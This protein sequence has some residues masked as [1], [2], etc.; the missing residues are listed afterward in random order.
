MTT[1]LTTGGIRRSTT[2]RQRKISH[3]VWEAK[4]IL[5][6]KIGALTVETQVIWEM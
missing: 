3:W 5:A 1:Y 4:A 2:E 6:R